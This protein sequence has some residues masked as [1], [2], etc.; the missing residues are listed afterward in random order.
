MLLAA[1]C[2]ALTFKFSFFSGNKLVGTNGHVFQSVTATNTVLLLLLTVI[3]VA[4]TVI[5]IFIF[6]NRKRQ[7]LIITG[8]IILSL[9]NIYLYYQASKE[10]IEGT[11]DLSALLSLAIPVL[12]I[13]AAR[14]IYKD[15]KL[16]KSVDRL[17]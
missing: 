12:L 2:A 3:I 13:L 7:L 9:L 10:F 15:Q 11:Y 8:L 16:V 17:R 6:K 5:N 4:G 14:G 1:L